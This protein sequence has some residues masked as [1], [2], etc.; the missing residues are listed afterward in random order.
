[1]QE[2][3][4]DILGYEGYYQVSNN[5]NVKSLER[6]VYK[7]GYSK[8]L[9]ERKL[10]LIKANDGYMGLILS[11]NGIKTRKT[12]H[13]LVAIAF[14]PNPEN[15]PQVNHINGIKTD[16]RIDNLEWCTAKE[17]INHAYSIGLM[18][19]HKGSSN[20]MYGRY[21]EL[22]H[23]FGKSINEKPIQQLD[24]N[25]NHIAYYDSI[26]KASRA[27]GVNNSNISSVCNG[28]RKTAGRFIWRYK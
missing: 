28:I 4:K 2:I 9:K 8:R 24:L 5:G 15:K 26:R 1:M 16:N 22:H 23:N 20:Y 14:I 11:Y 19:A 13:R 12:A 3:W 27:T 21:G 7:T 17:N 10:K 6:I 25:N 18:N